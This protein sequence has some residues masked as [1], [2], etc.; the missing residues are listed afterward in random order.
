MIP[1]PALTGRTVAV[2]GAAGFIGDAVVR[3]LVDHGADVVA[4]DGDSRARPGV[5][6]LV[7]DGRVR[8]VPTGHRWPYDDGAA[9]GAAAGGG[10]GADEAPWLAAVR[11]ADAI[12]HM[13]YSEPRTR[14]PVAEFGQELAEN[15]TTL[16][17]LLNHLTEAGSGAR[18]AEDGDGS[19]GDFHSP[20]FCFASSS[21]VYGRQFTR[22]VTEADPPKPDSPYGLA[23]VVAE[24]A[25][26]WW[27]ANG[28]RAVA[29]R[30]ATA[31]GPGETVPRA[32]P[33]FIRQVLAGRP[34]QVAIADDARDYIHVD[35][36]AGAIVAVLAASLPDCST[37]A[38]TSRP[39]LEIVNVAT[40]RATTT[41]ELAGLVASAAGSDLAAEVGEPTREPQMVV[42]D[43]S[44]LEAWTGFRPSI[45]L[46]DGLAD[47][48]EWFR[49][50]PHLWDDTAQAG[51]GHQIGTPSVEERP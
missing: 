24:Q 48:L 8:F 42:L 40:G 33:N 32:I 4:I 37:E 18:T 36:V 5:A 6:R 50:R 1:R 2:T 51:D 45:S 38:A 9:N 41:G 21:L 23:K 34:P 43:P 11:A 28:R 14:V 12:V 13:G 30:I 49:S 10:E 16:I 19:A 17:D 39:A 7:A 44:K 20:L 27:A 31:Y 22:A 47:E 46:E 3:A 26:A 25:L 29:L 35:D 15:V